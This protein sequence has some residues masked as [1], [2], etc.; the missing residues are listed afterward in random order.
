M[1]ELRF[2]GRVA[3]VTGAGGGLG[4]EYALLLAKRGAKVL[5]ND[6]GVSMS[7]DGTDSKKAQ[8]VADEINESGG[9]AI[10]NSDSVSTTSGAN[11][12]IK[13]AVDTWGKVD[14][15]INNAGIVT[16]GDIA[17]LSDEDW[18]F[19]MS[20]TAGGSMRMIRAVWKMMLDQNYGRIINVSS[21]SIFGMGANISYPAT[22]SALL[23]MTRGLS[24]TAEKFLE[25]NI[26]VNTIMPYAWSRLNILLGEEYSEQ[27]RINCPPYS[28]A[29]SVAL[30]CHE[31]APCNGEILIMGGGRVYRCFFGLTEGYQG[32]KDHTIE[33]V[34]DNWDKV[35]DTTNYT[36][37]AS[38]FEYRDAETWGAFENM[39][40]E[41]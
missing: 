30:L 15:L 23:G 36:I 5:V 21:G 40:K 39:F 33:D 12:I 1:S 3:V 17:T 31:E 19:D 38:T 29:P 18:E 16:G 7:G 24:V 41:V 6:L 27:Q 2:D 9:I 4:R 11:S 20:V 28:C 25:K 35:M 32:L 10:A 34:R 14:I 22:K 26:K 13:Q 8:Q 37:P